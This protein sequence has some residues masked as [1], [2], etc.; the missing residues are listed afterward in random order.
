MEERQIVGI[1]NAELQQ[2]FIQDN[3][4]YLDEWQYLQKLIAKV[5]LNRTINPPSEETRLLSPTCR[6]ITQTYSK[7]STSTT[8]T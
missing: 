7:C 8:A 3:K 5:F 4:R 2:K 1:G 6:M